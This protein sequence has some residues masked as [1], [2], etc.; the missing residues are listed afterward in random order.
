M[1]KFILFNSLLSSSILIFSALVTSAWAQGADIKVQNNKDILFILDASGSMKQV[2]AG[3]TQIEAAKQSL[4]TVLKTFP[5]T[6][7]VGL[8]V[9]A[10]R[11][12]QADK[13]KSCQDSELVTA[14]SAGAADDIIKK[15]SSIQPKGYT[16]ISYSLEQARADFPVS[17]ESEKTIILL[18]DGE[19]T[20]GGDPAATVKK[21]ISD[22]FK[23]SLQ[24]V[25]FNVD[26][27]ARAQLEAAATAGSGQYYAAK[28]A[29]E[30]SKALSEIT[31]KSL[32]IEKPK[33]VYGVEIRGGDSFET[34]VALEVG[35]EYRLDHHQKQHEYDYF[36]VPAKAGQEIIATLKTLEKGIQIRQDSKA[37]EGN[38]PYFGA[39][40]NAP[41]REQLAAKEIIG[42]K[43]GTE[44]LSVAAGEDGN[45]YLLVGSE[46]A[47]CHKDHSTFS[48]AIVA[49]GDLD[50]DVDA[51][52]TFET[53]APIEANKRYKSNFIG[54]PDQVDS[55]SFNAKAGEKFFIGF[56]P[57]EKFEYYT[58][59][60][61]FTEFKEELANKSFT[62]GRGGKTDL[63]EIAEDGVYYIEISLS[64]NEAELR[65]YA[66]ELRK[67]LE[68]LT[69]KGADEPGQGAE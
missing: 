30:L 19:E 24:V 47:D 33:S 23:F 61:V 2:T 16:P 51:G 31:K 38:S 39:K 25:G 7:N 22:G 20:C 57:G 6:V 36:L 8:R 44:Q 49:K 53:A 56:I 59:V 54:G 15:L 58:Y 28:D 1:K 12:N 27:K 48:I 26:A 43:F 69:E 52:S 63:V 14:L 64:S 68:P 50:T 29:A 9:Y 66:V 10:H 62:G 42:K 18:S 37:I 32:V 60:K 55:F 17:R 5:D 45:Y 46:Y 3:Q 4:T 40:L 65:P 13:E 11:E 34:A 41:N 21:L 35:K 67:K